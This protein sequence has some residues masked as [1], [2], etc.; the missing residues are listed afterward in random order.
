MVARV[1]VVVEALLAP[2]HPCA[3]T[4]AGVTDALGSCGVG[5]WT[6][7]RREV[8]VSSRTVTWRTKV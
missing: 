6:N 3:D 8:V 4:G 5:I 2:I 1:L 7:G